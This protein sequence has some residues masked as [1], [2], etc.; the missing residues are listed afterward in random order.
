M[1]VSLEG[2]LPL[3]TQKESSVNSDQEKEEDDDD[4]G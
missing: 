2:I 3:V 1:M 4:E